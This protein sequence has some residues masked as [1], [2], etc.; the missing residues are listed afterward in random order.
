MFLM[1]CTREF[2]FGMMIHHYLFNTFGYSMITY[3]LDRKFS[4]S[5][6]SAVMHFA[7]VWGRVISG[8]F[9]KILP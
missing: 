3:D 5:F 2:K 9:Q 6:I 4:R 8:H 1:D 7:M